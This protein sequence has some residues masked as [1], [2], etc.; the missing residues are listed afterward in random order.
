MLQLG[1]VLLE[2]ASYVVVVSIVSG[3][4]LRTLLRGKKIYSESQR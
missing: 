1:R 2:T 3:G 4:I